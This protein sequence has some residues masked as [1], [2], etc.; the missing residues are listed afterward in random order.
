M[1]DGVVSEMKMKEEAEGGIMMVV[2]EQ[3][4]SESMKW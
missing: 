3:K 4:R 2:G 1:R